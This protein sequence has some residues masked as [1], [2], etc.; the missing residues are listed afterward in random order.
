MKKRQ[1]T[2]PDEA[3]KAWVRS[4]S[5]IVCELLRLHP[6]VFSRIE[7]HHA[8]QRGLGQ[9]ADDRTCIPLCWRHHDRRS[10]VSVHSLGK[11]FWTRFG[12]DRYAV[13]AEVRRRYFLE[14]GDVERAA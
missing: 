10:Q 2:P 6:R 1:S 12:L 4:Q 9:T 5:C 11:T 13:I 8:G 7:A 14:K 3:Y